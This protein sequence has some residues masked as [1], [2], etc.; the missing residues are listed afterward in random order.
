MSPEGSS[1]LPTTPRPTSSTAIISVIAGVL[2]LTLFPLIG[3]VIAVI[4]GAM[5]RREIQMTAG[6][7]EGEGL[8]TAGLILGW[9]GVGLSA[10]GLC[11]AGLV[12]GLPICL[13]LFAISGSDFGGV[14]PM[15]LALL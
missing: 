3:S 6:A 12:I 4:T 14:L 5:A 15:A 2:G 13:A 9:V 8:A 1:R 10:I 7:I 11:V